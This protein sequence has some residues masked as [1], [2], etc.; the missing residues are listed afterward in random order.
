[1]LDAPLPLCVTQW[2]RAQ[3]GAWFPKAGLGERSSRLYGRY[4][5]YPFATDRNA[6][7]EAC[8]RDLPDH[9]LLLAPER[10]LS[11]Y[12]AATASSR[13]AEWCRYK[14]SLVAPVHNDLSQRIFDGLLTGQV[15]LAPEELTDL[16]AVIPPDLQRALP[17]VRYSLKDVGSVARAHEAAVAAFDR[18][19]QAGVERRHAYALENHMFDNR[20][21]ALFERALARAQKPAGSGA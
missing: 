1:M 14:T 6:F 8:L 19:G 3:A 20:V 4:V 11:P 5:R 2:S 7:L 9:D 18:D 10:E 15:P 16:D 21:S 17:V 13:F 12:F